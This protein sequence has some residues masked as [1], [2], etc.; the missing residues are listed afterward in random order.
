MF[1]LFSSHTIFPLRDIVR[2]CDHSASGSALVLPCGLQNTDSLVVSAETVNPRFDQDESEFR[3]F[4]FAISLEVL[5]DGDGL[6][7]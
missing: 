4:V 1:V 2:L 5:S 6:E 7:E 3:V